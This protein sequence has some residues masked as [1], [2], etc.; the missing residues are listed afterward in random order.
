LA[1]AHFLVTNLHVADN[2]VRAQLHQGLFAW[3]AGFYR[4]I[5]AHGYRFGAVPHESLRFFPLVPMA[6]RGL[7]VIL[8]GRSDIALLI[9]AN[10]SALGMAALLHRLV[11]IEK[12]DPALAR[13]AAWL[14]AL[15]PPSFVLVLGY[16]EATF[17]ALGVGMFIALRTSRW[18]WAAALGVLAGLTRPLG[19][20]LAVPAAIEA[21]RSLVI[22]HQAGALE[23]QTGRRSHTTKTVA[24]R[25]VAVIGPVAGTGAFLAWAGIRYGDALLPLH[26]QQDA[27]HRGSVVDPLTALLHEGRG[28]LH[29]HHVGSGLHVPWAIALAVLV[30][31]CARRW[32]AC[33]AAFAGVMLL[34]ALSSKN[35]DSLERYALSAFPFVLV[36]ASLTKSQR[37]ER[38]GL[39]LGAT[40]MEGYSLLAF[41]NAVVP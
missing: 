36:G 12:G 4:G 33:Y 39:V 29:G 16:S 2:A 24:A 3:D 17:M 32:P 5:A 27:N 9:L 35:L 22:A 40:A 38:L 23:W 26:I 21:G 19:A 13:R 20:L 14:V 31:V 18:G 30:I 11:L 37:V 10:G 25:A 41:L 15:V 6:A 1:L 7:G 8:G 28:I 34:A